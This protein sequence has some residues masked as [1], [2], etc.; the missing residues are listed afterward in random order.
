MKVSRNRGGMGE[1]QLISDCSSDQ[2]TRLS[3]K[4]DGHEWD[5]WVETGEKRG[6]YM[7]PLQILGIT[8]M[9][10]HN[11]DRCCKTCPTTILLFLNIDE[12]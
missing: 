8:A 2:F 10:L 7:R 4:S 11:K 1:S 5:G 12:K 9:Q 3:A 6:K